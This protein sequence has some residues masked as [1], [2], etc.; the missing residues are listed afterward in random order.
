M[1][2]QKIIRNKN[3]VKDTPNGKILIAGYGDILT[4][5]ANCCNPVLGDEIVGYITKGNGVSIHRKDCK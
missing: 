5:L 1:I 2:Q 4:S 3:I